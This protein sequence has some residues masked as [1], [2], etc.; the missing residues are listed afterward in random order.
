MTQSKNIFNIY[1]PLTFRGLTLLA[2]AI[3]FLIGPVRLKSDIIAA[4]F[5]VCTLASL[6][7]FIGL[8]LLSRRRLK[9][10]IKIVLSAQSESDP[11]I[12]EIKNLAGEDI[13]IVSKVSG[14][15]VS[16]FFEL[17]FQYRIKQDGINTNI[18]SLKPSCPQETFIIE[19]VV[20]P[21]RGKWEIEGVS[22]ELVDRLGFTKIPLPFW[23]LNHIVNVEPK[24]FHCPR[25]PVLASTIRVDDQVNHPVERKGDLYDLKQY[26]P[27]DGAR[28]IVWKLF[29]KSGQLF[30]RYPEPAYSPEGKVAFFCLAKK[31]DDK[32]ASET[33]AYLEELENIDIE[34]LFV[35]LTSN[36]AIAT[37]VD[38]AKEILIEE[39]WNSELANTE[40]AKNSIN[41][42]ISEA[43][44][45]N[46]E[47]I[48]QSV[49][50]AISEQ[51]LQNQEYRNMLA[52]CQS[53]LAQSGI[54]SSI[55]MSSSLSSGSVYNGNRNESSFSRGIKK[56]LIENSKQEEVGINP[57]DT[58]AFIASID[59][60]T[61]DL[62]WS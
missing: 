34:I 51:S 21:H 61:S 60:T 26:H 27:A 53:S 15:T 38:S 17:R 40:S 30:S 12:T 1:C 33:I 5:S 22:L 56:F 20:F 46:H 32:L 24:P 52:D 11:S 8:A 48:V 10:S 57:K 16:P 31:T 50:L 54:R 18:H 37:S 42:L 28:K 13:A 58:Q 3:Y 45:N 44:G 2:L 6:G 14:I 62:S 19:A 25:W 39:S 7:L 23:R 4:G 49:I 55:F 35:A 43:Q 36:P 47:R 41:A 59:P 9:K 29:A